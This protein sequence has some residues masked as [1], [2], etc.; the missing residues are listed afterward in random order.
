MGLNTQGSNPF[1]MQ[2]MLYRAPRYVQ[3]NC[4]TGLVQKNH[5]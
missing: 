2:K 5:T 3:S 1:T 4:L